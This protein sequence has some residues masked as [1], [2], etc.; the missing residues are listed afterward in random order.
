M[1]QGTGQFEASRCRGRRRG[2]IVKVSQGAIRPAGF[3]LLELLVVMA[4]IVLLVA[5]SIPAIKTLTQSNGQAQAVNLVRTMISTARSIAISQHRMA[6]VVFF[7]E[8]STFSQPVN[9]DRTAMQICVEDY[10]QG[11]YRIPPLYHVFVAYSSSRQ[12]LPVDVKLAVLSDDVSNQGN[13]DVANHPNVPSGT[14]LAN[15]RAIMFDANG[16][17]VLIQNMATPSPYSRWN[18]LPST[19]DDKPGV[20]NMQYGDWRFFAANN[21]GGSPSG[22]G[23][24]PQTSLTASANS[25]PGIFLYSKSDFDTQAANQSNGFK[26]SWLKDHTDV[27]IV[28]ANTG[29]VLQ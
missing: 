27:I 14:L 28:N 12:Y 6:G 8:T 2:L 24:D 19:P 20:G 4:I 25:Y 1:C 7:E 17:M 10:N 26:A 18:L 9:G 15:G 29:T 13:V 11:Q 22:T 21:G 3:T 5:L 23:V 16:Q